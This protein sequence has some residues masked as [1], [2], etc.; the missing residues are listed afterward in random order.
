[1]GPGAHLGAVSGGGQRIGQRLKARGHVGSA[2]P[3]QQPA[4]DVR[5]DYSDG[6]AEGQGRHRAC[7]VRADPG[8]AFQSGHVGR[9]AIPFHRLR[10]CLEG[11][12]TAVVAQPAPLGQHGGRRRRGQFS[13]GRKARHE[14]REPLGNAR[15]LRLLEHHLADQDGVR[16]V[17]A[18]PRKVALLDG[19]PAEEGF[20]NLGQAG[21]CG[22][23]FEGSSGAVGR[24]GPW[25][26]ATVA[27]P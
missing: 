25:W 8:Q 5:V 2:E 19:V 7:G 14:P 1:M 20:A 26:C 3:P 11:E 17:R 10:R 21:R 24:I 16:I 12:R 9:P 4:S 27:A 15:C 23:A 22:H 13:D 18:T 6:T